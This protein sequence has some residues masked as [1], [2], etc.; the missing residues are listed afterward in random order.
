MS[1]VDDQEIRERR[2]AAAYIVGE[3]EAGNILRPQ[4]NA[5]ILEQFLDM[6]VSAERIEAFVTPFR[7]A[8]DDVDKT[9][10]ARQSRS[11]VREAVAPK[12]K[13]A[14][15]P[16]PDSSNGSDATLSDGEED[17]G[18]RG[19]GGDDKGRK[20]PWEGKGKVKDQQLA[21]TLSLRRKYRNRLEKAKDAIVTSVGAP[22][23]PEPL[24]TTI[25]KHGYVDFDKLNGAHFSAVNEEEG[26]AATI[27]E[28]TIRLKSKAVTKSVTTSTDW[29]YCYETYE[30][31]VIWAY[32]H[33]KKELRTY[34]A[35]FHQL[36][37]SYA[38]NAHIRLIN[39]D[40][41]IRNE[42]ASSTLCK[43]TDDALFARLREQYLSVDG[44]GYQASS[45]TGIRAPGNSN[46]SGG[47]GSR[48]RPKVPQ[49]CRQWNA[50]RCSRPEGECIYLHQCI[51][52]S[53][54]HPQ[55]KCPKTK[56]GGGGRVA[57][58]E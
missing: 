11:P 22:N 49:A 25:L 46:S 33:R 9:R 51:D 53:G 24:W 38:T 10:I 57:N 36:F 7:E 58:R 29:L 21:K 13:R 45:S 37:R 14:R 54:E 41:A 1:D 12:K 42:V 26:H 30:R 39:L 23:F 52:C 17:G 32:P 47:G 8:L 18:N 43:L 4:A 48:S 34:Y 2:D 3:Y 5:S 16:S 28:Y 44:A 35:Q 15:S 56:S 20:W 27:G 19:D 6:G 50:N 55:N 40:R 31:A